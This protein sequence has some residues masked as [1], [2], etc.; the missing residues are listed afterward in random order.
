MKTLA[1]RILAGL[2]CALALPAAVLAQATYPSRPIEL[3]V[4]YPAGG[5]TDVLG[6]AFALA[7]AKH[8]PQS[9]IV[10]NKPG[11]SGAIGWSDVINGKQDGYKVALLATDLMTQP[12]MGLTKITYEDFI[13]I[14]RLNYDPAAITVRADAPW[15][16]VEEFL[17]AA[18]KGDFRVGN[19][20]N[21]STWHLA[22]AAVEDK[23]GVKFNHIPFAGAAPA[24]LSLLGGHIEAI[25][26]SAAEVYTYTST[27]KLKAL[28]VMS[29]QRIKGFEKVP[30]LKE[31]NID[32]SI[33]TWRGLAVTKGTPPEIVNLLRAA[34]AKIVAE[35][36]LR[37]ALDRQ[38]MGYAYADGEAF[39]AVMAKDHAFYKG[40]INKLGLKQ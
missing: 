1:S 15:N 12:N 39:G 26:V 19:G 13:P 10:V 27:G 29:E 16:T 14:A 30:T 34:T 8:L 40:L 35:Q 5:G 22:A 20:G 7:S 31:R 28:A 24:A 32:V 11:A 2:L 3:V 23:T 21:G 4:P 37:D 17:A 33:G 6:R 38:N 36:S 25:T 9:L 18:K